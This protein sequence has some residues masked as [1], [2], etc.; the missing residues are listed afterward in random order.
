LQSRIEEIRAA[1]GEVLAVS[2]DP[3][4]ETRRRLGSKGFEF[5]LLADPGL[6]AIDAFGVRHPGGGMGG[7][8]LARPAVFVIDRQ[9]RIAWRDLTDNWRV[10]VRPER[11]LEQLQA[12][13]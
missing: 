12:L 11:V 4:E 10:R 6:E 8:D 2:T 7:V 5:P 1:G 9:G 13:Q 3:A